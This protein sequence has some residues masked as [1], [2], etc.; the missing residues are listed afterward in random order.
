M[1]PRRVR[2]RT[3]DHP[4]ERAHADRGDRPRACRPQG[5]VHKRC[6]DRR[7]DP[8]RRHRGRGCRPFE[9]DGGAVGSTVISQISAGRKNRLWLE[10]DGAEESLAFDQEEP[11]SLWCGRREAATI[12]KRDP[13]F[14]SPPAARLAWLPAGHAQGY[15]DCFDAFV[16]DTYASIGSDEPADG[17]PLFADGLRTAQITARCSPLP[18]KTAG[19]TFPP[20]PRWRSSDEQTRPRGPQHRQAVPRRAGPRRRRLRRVARRG[21]R[22]SRAQRRREVHA[23]QV[24]VGGGGAVGGR[25]PRRRRAAA[26]RRAVGVDGARR[27]DDLPGARP[28]RGPER[29]RER[30]PGP[31]D[32]PGGV[33]DRKA[34][35]RETA[36]LLKRLDHENISPKRARPLAAAGRPADRLDRPGTV[37]QDQAC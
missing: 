35:R 20:M 25:D 19:L 13:A 14:L 26:D 10:V 37:A 23:D 6:G 24:R 7:R 32:P 2:H 30:V 22:S 31:R 5:G 4:P 28:R 17:L 1:R 11:E 8:R 16:A 18:A 29:R 3:P 27:R 36:E 9:T 15:A 33:L 12:L 21:A 34:M